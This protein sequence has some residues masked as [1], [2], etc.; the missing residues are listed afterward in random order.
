M[1]LPASS[2]LVS[3]QITI[4][5]ESAR[6]L[7]LSHILFQKGQFIWGHFWNFLF[8]GSCS[9]RAKFLSQDSNPRARM[10]ALFSQSP[11]WRARHWVSGG[12]SGIPGLPLQALDP[13]PTNELGWENEDLSIFSVLCLRLS[14]RLVSG[15]L[16]KKE[17]LQVALIWGSVPEAY[18]RWC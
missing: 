7:E 4:A 18:M 14:L 17:P 3:T 2:W 5:F 16:C 9:L 1:K 6:R 12:A 15:C 10:A 8:H 11:A 13:H